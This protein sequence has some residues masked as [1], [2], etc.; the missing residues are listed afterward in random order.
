MYQDD[1]VTDIF[2]LMNNE[3]NTQNQGEK[4]SVD[5]AFIDVLNLKNDVDVFYIAERA[6]LSV[7]KVICELNGVIYQ[8][9][10]WFVDSD[11]YDET[12]G[13]LYSAEELYEKMLKDLDD[14]IMEKYGT[15]L[16]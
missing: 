15:S 1:T 12:E 10:E 3:T 6:G 13:R 4:L 11:K 2:N 9:P 7:S 16:L 8:Q 14:K 5:D